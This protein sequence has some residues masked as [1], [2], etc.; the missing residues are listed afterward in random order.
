[1][2]QRENP[3]DQIERLLRSG[4]APQAAAA[5]T[6]LLAKVPS[7]FPA[8]LGRARAYLMADR[9]IEAE[10][11]LRE[12]LRL[13]PKDELANLLRAQLDLSYG[14]FDEAFARLG[15]L[16][17][18]RGQL[19][20]DATIA[21]LD[22]LSSTGRREEMKEIGRRGGSWTSDPRAPL[23]LAR[24]AAAEDPR[25]GIEGMLAIFRGRHPLAFRR[26]AGFEAVLLLDRLGE[27]REAFATATEVHGVTSPPVE[28]NGPVFQPLQEL[29][30][31]LERGERWI[32]PR[33]APVSGVA[34]MLALPRS[35]TTLLEQMLDRHPDI[36]GIGEYEGLRA[37]IHGLD[38]TGFWPRRPG[39]IAT[40]RLAEL[41]A[42]YLE[43]AGHIR[44]P[45]A[46][47]IFD[48]FLRAW[49]SIPEIAAVLPGAVGIAVDRDPRDTAT[50]IHLSYFDIG[51]TAW[52]GDFVSM[53]K[54]MTLKRRIT[55]LSVRLF[56]MPHVHISY[57]DLVEDPAYH[58]GR[59]LAMMGLP[60]DPRVLHPEANTRQTVTL[61]SEP[62]KRPI[63]RNSIGRW[64]NYEFAFDGAW[65]ALADEHAQLTERTRAA[66]LAS[67]GISGS[68]P[69]IA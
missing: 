16:A 58:A 69:A 33:V 40:A 44:R 31:M 35:G 27:Y 49:R 22:A 21:M 43:G 62:V 2:A 59:C 29:L 30:A 47:W 53:R 56:E 12:A 8:Y 57:E 13:S 7:S 38:N 41:Q 18:G 23:H 28:L 45:G 1:M 6:A 34:M 66:R 48:K 63:N 3:I 51:V 24:I 67:A 19:A 55:E 5:A 39:A 36:S 50:S 42:L 25:R 32:Q 46:P 17:A 61:S 65:D 20:S 4:E 15:P 64:R 60:M 68:N 54:A 9:K 11:D 10:R 26:R 37:I 52:G 14:K